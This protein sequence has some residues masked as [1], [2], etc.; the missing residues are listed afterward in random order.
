MITE[1]TDLPT[2]VIVF[3]ASG[4]LHAEEYRDVLLPAIERAAST[5]KDRGIADHCL[6]CVDLGSSAIA[7]DDD[8]TA[9]S[10]H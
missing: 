9:R 1:L 6:A 2:D 5:A 7:N 8:A 10:E 4:K 3:E